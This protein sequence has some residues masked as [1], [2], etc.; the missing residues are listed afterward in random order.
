MNELET[1]T[2]EI[3]SKLWESKRI[4]KTGYQI[5]SDL[6]R[7]A[8]SYPHM[9]CF[10]QVQSVLEVDS[11]VKRI[12]HITKQKKSRSVTMSLARM[13][14]HYLGKTVDKE[15]QVSDWMARP[16]T[17]KQSDYA[18]LDA[19]ISPALVEKA[20]ESVDARINGD[21][22]RIERWQGDE[23]LSKAIESWR[24]FIL[25]S[26]DP[27]TIQK[28]QAKQIVGPSWTV[29]Q[30]WITGGNPPEIPF[31]PSANAETP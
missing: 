6:R 9:P 27:T 21:L 30:S 18:A 14:S 13:T 26:D 29:A 16:L 20:L 2:S 8:A 19:A 10:Q 1:A 5:G 15:C 28:L 22:P 3:L 23:G 4:L 17:N 24:F 12:L 25:E 7:I 31:V 11:L